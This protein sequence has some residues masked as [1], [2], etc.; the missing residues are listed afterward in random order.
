MSKDSSVAT[1]GEDQD[2]KTADAAEQA[3]KA[4]AGGRAPSKAGNKPAAKDGLDQTLVNQGF[5]GERV[6]VSLPAARDDEQDFV[7]V[8]VNTIGFQIPRGKPFSVPVEVCEVLD[9]AV[10]K[11][12]G[13]DGVGRDVPRH[14]YSVR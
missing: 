5:S 10:E 6:T 9:N 13:R 14:P 11:R 4:S 3:A 12:Y 8:S 2:T 7:F 1:L